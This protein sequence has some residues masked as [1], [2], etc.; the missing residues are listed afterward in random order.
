MQLK[1][2]IV[3]PFPLTSGRYGEIKIKS[4]GKSLVSCE[5]LCPWER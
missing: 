2:G 4:A 3:K 1:V 5:A